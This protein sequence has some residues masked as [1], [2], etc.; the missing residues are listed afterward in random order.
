[1]EELD[2]SL[3]IG[4]PPNVIDRLVVEHAHHVAQGVDFGDLLQG[5][6]FGQRFFFNARAQ[7]DLQARTHLALGPVQFDQA[8]EA[9]VL[10]VG[11]AARGG[12]RVGVSRECRRA[13]QEGEQRFLAGL[14]KTDDSDP[15]RYVGFS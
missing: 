2:L 4:A 7:D 6:T 11:H 15:H 12:T 8:I 10:H 9:L 13:N 3:G 14:R 5:F 1:V